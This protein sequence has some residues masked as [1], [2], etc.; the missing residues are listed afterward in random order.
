MFKR[1]KTRTE[2]VVDDSDW[3]E[4]VRCVTGKRYSLQQ[5]DDCM[6][7]CRIKIQVPCD[8][9]HCKTTREDFDEDPY[10][11]MCVSLQDW[12]NTPPE[13]YENLVWDRNFYPDRDELA[14]WLYEA[15]VLP[16]GT[17][18]INVDW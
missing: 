16:E 15:G 17:Y 9:G 12:L 13:R 5:Q 18:T 1:L 7:R 6:D 11:T 2:V 10:A 4:F 3:D 8:A 14:N